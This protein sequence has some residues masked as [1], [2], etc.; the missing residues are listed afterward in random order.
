MI[1]NG[2]MKFYIT[3]LLQSLYFK[4][5]KLVPCGLL[6][7]RFKVEL[8]DADE[9][10]ITILGM[11]VGLGKIQQSLKNATKVKAKKDDSDLIFKIDDEVA[12]T[13]PPA[14]K[15]RKHPFYLGF[16]NLLKN[17][18]VSLFSFKYYTSKFHQIN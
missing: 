7:L 3:E 10:Q 8:P 13:A 15:D 12:I 2:M 4:L 16:T 5:R 14:S 6:R 17:S 18:H 11:A 1:F 9:I